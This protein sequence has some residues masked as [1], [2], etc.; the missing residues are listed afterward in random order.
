MNQK[1]TLLK[2]KISSPRWHFV[3]DVAFAKM[4]CVTADSLG[5]VFPSPNFF[6]P[7]RSQRVGQG[8]LKFDEFG[9]LKGAVE[10]AD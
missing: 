9:G 10:M 4:G 2:T 8:D 6:S 7:A 3:D 1:V 5:R